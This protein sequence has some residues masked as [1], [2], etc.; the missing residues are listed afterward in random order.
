MKLN[1]AIWKNTRQGVQSTSV[2]DTVGGKN[3]NNDT[4]SD[5]SP[6][7]QRDGFV[8]TYFT[9]NTVYTNQTGKFL[10]SSRWGIK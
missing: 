9:K 4:D 7:K 6:K 10:V 3:Q 2:K 8:K 5:E 1:R